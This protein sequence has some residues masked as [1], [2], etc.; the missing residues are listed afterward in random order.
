MVEHF[1]ES[2]GRWMTNLALTHWIFHWRRESFPLFYTTTPLN[3]F[4]VIVRNS[5]H[6]HRGNPHRTMK[7]KLVEFSAV[8]SPLERNHCSTFQCTAPSWGNLAF[9]VLPRIGWRSPGT[10]T[11][12]TEEVS[13]KTG[14]H[15]RR[16]QH[17]TRWSD[18]AATMDPSFFPVRLSF[19]NCAARLVERATLSGEPKLPRE[20]QP[21]F[22]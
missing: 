2:N 3:S 18:T 13:R 22:W 14:R 16:A 15:F 4:T 1:K 20:D 11:T 5:K 10:S 17:S 9:S 21:S 8:I 6:I 19:L 12:L 7:V